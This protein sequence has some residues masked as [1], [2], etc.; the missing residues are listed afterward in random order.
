MCVIEL[1]GLEVTTEEVSPVIEVVVKHKFGK[2]D[3]PNPTTNQWIVD[4]G[5]FLSKTWIVIYIYKE[6][7][8]RRWIAW[9]IEGWNTETV[10]WRQKHSA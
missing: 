2:L 8:T 5:H 4:K 3:L 7:K 1:A 9:W 10:G 6:W